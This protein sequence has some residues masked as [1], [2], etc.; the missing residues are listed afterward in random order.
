M[1]RTSGMARNDVPV[2]SCAPVP[3]K[4]GEIQAM[5]SEWDYATLPQVDPEEEVP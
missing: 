3:L 2:R 4:A 1:T 5:F